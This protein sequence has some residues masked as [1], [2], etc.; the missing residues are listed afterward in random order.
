M[1]LSFTG[2][3][4]Q[5]LGGRFVRSSKSSSL[6]EDPLQLLRGLDDAVDDRLLMFLTGLLA[7]V[8]EDTSEW[9]LRLLLQVLLER[10]RVSELFLISAG[11]VFLLETI[12]RIS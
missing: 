11:D 2:R 6:K 5:G 9:E 7:F 12:W 10:T 4:M 1:G 3:P 8:K